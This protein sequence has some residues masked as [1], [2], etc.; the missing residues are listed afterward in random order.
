MCTLTG[1]RDMCAL[2]DDQSAVLDREPAQRKAPTTPAPA[3]AAHPAAGRPARKIS[4]S[5]RAN[6]SG[7]HS[8][9]EA[10][11][12]PASTNGLSP[13]ASRVDIGPRIP[14]DTLSD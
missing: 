6:V 9:W 13:S 3:S 2:S 4:D 1:V 11:V 10:S 8:I 14:S 12:H 5:A 7:T